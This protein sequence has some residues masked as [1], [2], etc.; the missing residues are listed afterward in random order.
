MTTTR[1]LLG[2][3]WREK[4]LIGGGILFT[5]LMGLVE[6]GTG[7]ILKMLTDGIEEISRFFKH[8]G[9]G[10]VEIPFKI[11]IPFP[12][13]KGRFK[14]LDTVVS[15]ADE[16][17]RA[18]LYLALAVIVLYLLKAIF[19]YTRE[20]CMNSAIQRILKRFRSEVFA[21]LLGLPLAFHDRSRSGDLVSRVTYDVTTLERVLELFIEIART[22][23][24]MLVFLPVMFVINPQIT[25]FTML[26]FP[27]SWLLITRFSRRIR[28]VGR[29]ISETV[30][31]YTAV[32]QDRTRNLRTIKGLGAEAAERGIFDALVDRNYGLFVRM[33]RLKYLMKPSNELIGMIGVSLVFIYFAGRL[34][35]GDTTLG[36]VVLYL[37]LMQQAYKPVKKVAAAFG[38]LYNTLV[39][40][41]R[42][43][44]LFDEKEEQPEG[45]ADIPAAGTVEME[46]LSFRYEGMPALFVGFSCRFP[47]GVTALTGNSGS[48][49]TTLCALIQRF[50]EPTVGTVTYGGTPLNDLP[51]AEWRKLV[52]YA[53]PDS[54]L[55]AG[56][57]A[58]N[59]RYGNDAG[60]EAT[61]AAVT[62]ALDI[63]DDMLKTSVGEG[64]RLLAQGQREKAVLARAILRRPRIL[65]IDELCDGMDKNRL[66]ALFEAVHDIP[67][68]IIVSKDQSVLDRTAIVVRI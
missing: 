12:G 39:C 51:L 31:D 22:A 44:S 32:M 49:K 24:Y 25:L 42:I 57:V 54:A 48:G 61:L 29:D 56:T 38:E 52:A 5:A 1:R 53:G 37:Y 18:M 59:L 47:Q 14:L 41:G 64:G 6:V 17:Y 2:Y 35:A 20:I 11:K 15:G 36:N 8:G 68:V 30:G 27:L 50:Y 60:D 66:D 58:E 9:D 4:R 19:E 63:A 23:V 3:L 28:R 62:A 26:F 43:F 13:S 10:I 67:T 16:V 65:L 34:V 21:K 45:S 46:G 40:T 7:T 33:I 55:F